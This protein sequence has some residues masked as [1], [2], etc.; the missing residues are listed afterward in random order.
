MRKRAKYA[1]EERRKAGRIGVTLD[2]DLVDRLRDICKAAGYARAEDGSGELASPIVEDLLRYAVNA[3]DAG[4]FELS[5]EV[6]R[7]RLKP[8]GG[9][10]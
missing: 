6:T 5:A 4:A 10:R 1:S 9:K 8:D 3:Y 2:P 7:A